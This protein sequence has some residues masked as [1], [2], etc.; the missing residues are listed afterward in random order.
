MNFSLYSPASNAWGLYFLD[1]NA[2][3]ASFLRSQAHY[4]ET[5]AAALRFE[6]LEQK[7]AWLDLVDW[8]F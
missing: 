5:Q 4:A 3:F 7:C 6:K 2:E 1:V 8:Y